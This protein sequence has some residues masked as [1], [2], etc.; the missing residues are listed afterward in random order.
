M[1]LA[2]YGSGGFGREVYDIAQRRNAVS[3]MWDKIVFIDDIREE[4]EFNNTRMYHFETLAAKADAY[5]II[6]AV[7]EPSTREKLFGKAVEA[8]F[9]PA[10]LIDPTALIS[11]SAKIGEGTIICEFSTIHCNVE[12][13]KNNIVQPYNN[14][15]HD[16]KTG[17][18]CVFGTNFAP[19]GHS[20]FGDRVFTG[21]NSTS[22]ENLMIG[23][24]VIFAMGAVVF[25]DVPA[26]SV[27]IGN[28]ARVTRG[29]DEG[30][31]F[32]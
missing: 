2:I 24:D 12:I 8:G 10:T 31:V 11:P 27:M 4:S 25:K 17:N 23:D 26:G 15:G 16:I 7:G 3:H 5:E 18:H 14:F 28:P 19:G 13:G 1:I 20:V 32:K 21:M 29:N 6:I 30:K 22:K 9:K